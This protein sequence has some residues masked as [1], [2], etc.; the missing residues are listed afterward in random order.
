MWS[1]LSC[2]IQ[3]AK[4]VKLVALPWKFEQETWRKHLLVSVLMF[5]SIQVVSQK[6]KEK[7][8][9]NSKAQPCVSKRKMRVGFPSLDVHQKIRLENSVDS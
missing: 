6:R 4:E 7:I 3:D 8:A 1:T 9:W 5:W 2:R